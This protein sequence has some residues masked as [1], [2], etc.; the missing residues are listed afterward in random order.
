M[1]FGLWLRDEAVEGDTAALCVPPSA[2]K[3]T[4]DALPVEDGVAPEPDRWVGRP[5]SVLG[6]VSVVGV[7]EV[8][9]GLIGLTH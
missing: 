5:P 3:G 1:P 6:G 7:V 4:L 8:P 2:G 9:E